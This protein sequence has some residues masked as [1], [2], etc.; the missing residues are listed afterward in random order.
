MN[1]VT[2]DLTVEILCIR[3]DRTRWVERGWSRV[4]F[5][6]IGRLHHQDVALVGFYRSRGIIL[7]TVHCTG[8]V[9]TSSLVVG[10]P[11]EWNTTTVK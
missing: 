9:A 5:V 7:D 2:V 11:A 10:K 3:S 8:I 6:P 4:R 1:N